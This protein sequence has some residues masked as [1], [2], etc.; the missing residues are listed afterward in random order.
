MSNIGPQLPPHLQRPG[1]AESD[2]DSSSDG[3]H[4]PQLP[5]VACRGPAPALPAEDSDSSDDYGPALPPGL[6][7]RPETAESSDEDEDCIG[8]RIE[9]KSSGAIDVGREVE[10]RARRMADRLAGVG[11]EPELSRE[12]WMLELPEEKADRFG[13]GPR[14]FSRK[15]AHER[16]KDR[17][18]W[19]DSPAARE[20]KLREGG[21]EEEEVAAS[22]SDIGDKIRD[23]EME[24]VASQLK[25]K[26]GAESLMD[27]H[28][29]KLKKK[30][31]EEANKLAASG[32]NQERR[33]FD[34]DIDLK[35][36]RFDDAMKKNM[37]KAAAKINDRFSSGSKKYL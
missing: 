28:E 11:Q 8:P 12:T 23:Q 26:R 5:A 21:E 29:K 32:E 3:S 22:P 13:L 33:P 9:E 31:K 10:E 17:S 6:Q 1:Q 7:Q 15:G 4:G 24:R 16:G 19:T 2:S 37:L 35:A 14:Q 27:K 36:N 34:R 30:K 20:R 18:A 25:Q